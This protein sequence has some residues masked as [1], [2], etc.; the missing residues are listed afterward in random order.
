MA[1]PTSVTVFGILNIVFGV[2]G[3]VGG[4]CAIG[5][6]LVRNAGNPWLPVMQDNALLRGWIICANSLGFIASIALCAAGIGLLLL[7][8]WARVLSIVYGILAIVLEIVGTIISVVVLLPAVMSRTA[9]L[10]G[11]AALGPRVGAIGATVGGCFGLVYPVLLLI[12]MTRPKVVAAFKAQPDAP[13]MPG[14]VL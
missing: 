12:F 3:L 8:E 14:N 10:Q 9:G 5:V 11:P 4:C 7:K 6:L 2:L 1:R 13:D